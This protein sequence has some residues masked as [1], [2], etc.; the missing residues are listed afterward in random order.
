[1]F[2]RRIHR[3][4]HRFCRKPLTLNHLRLDKT[5]YKK[6]PSRQ[7]AI[8]G[9]LS[10]YTEVIK[11][12]SNILMFLLV[13]PV[14][15]VSSLLSK[16][17]VLV[18]SNIALAVVNVGAYIY[19]Y[20]TNK[21]TLTELVVIAVGIAI[22]AFVILALT[23]S[24]TI[25]FPFDAILFKINI[26]A[27]AIN[28]FE[29][30]RDLVV[31][32]ANKIFERFKKWFGKPQLAVEEEELNEK[33]DRPYLDLIF[34]KMFGYRMAKSKNKTQE[35]QSIVDLQKILGR[36][37]AKWKEPFWGFILNK[38]NITR[39]ETCRSALYDGEP[40]GAVEWLK[41]KVS[42]KFT[43]LD[44]INEDCKKLDDYWEKIEADPDFNGELDADLELG[45]ENFSQISAPQKEKI[46]RGKKVLTEYFDLQV[47]KTKDNIKGLPVNEHEK[48][49]KELEDI[50]SAFP[51]LCCAA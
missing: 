45:L 35:L 10:K 9:V 29:P 17:T 37:I 20:F 16:A 28:G 39:L 12:I 13:A 22:L 21:R 51:K 36:Y 50:Q 49:L 41:D 1:M 11:Y 32:L 46:K 18:G 34:R 2:H 3:L 24:I 6:K 5:K 43:K 8:K 42:F 27:Y 19:D 7:E 33:R 47:K 30:L 26:I 23:P 44:K 38:R 31:A 14:L 4:F 25:V 15:V 40:K 48:Y